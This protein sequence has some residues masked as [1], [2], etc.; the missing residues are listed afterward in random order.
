MSTEPAAPAGLTTQPTAPQPG[1][2]PS[3]T[4]TTESQTSPEPPKVEEPKVE[5]AKKEE[6][7]PEA[8]P[9]VLTDIKV[10][11]GFSLDEKQGGDFLALMNDG[12]LSP[13]ERA[14]KL[15]DLY[16]GIMKGASEK[17]TSEF[18]NLQASWREAIEKDPEIGGAN[19]ASTTSGI[20]RLVE[21][22][23]SAEAREAF[24]TTGAGNNPHIVRM[25]AKMA[26][27]LNEP[28]PVPGG[29]AASSVPLED[30][31]YTKGK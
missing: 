1:T 17:G 4:P 24:D 28:G 13:G 7:K 21:K 5:E 31:L 30:R 26:K 16:A 2:T 20:G 10:P 18:M 12:A 8:K 9:L 19:L 11:E 6:A 15:V 29:S 3:I 14:Q 23:G 27:D 25:L 22:Y